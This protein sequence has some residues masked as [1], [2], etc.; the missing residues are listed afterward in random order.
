MELTIAFV[1]PAEMNAK[2][3][4]M[5]AFK[6]PLWQERAHGVR[7]HLKQ[8]DVKRL[9]CANIYL[10]CEELNKENNTLYPTPAPTEDFCEDGWATY[11]PEHT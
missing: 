9:I 8:A 2:A 1:F 6:D 7:N 4:T 3:V 11:Y 10:P 5:A